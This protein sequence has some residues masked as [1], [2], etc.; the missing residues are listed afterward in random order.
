MGAGPKGW[1]AQQHKAAG[2]KRGKA[3]T[4]PTGNPVLDQIREATE[5][6]DRLSAQVRVA[7]AGYRTSVKY[8]NFPLGQ[9][10]RDIAAMLHFPG[11]AP[12]RVLSTTFGGF[13][14]HARQK[15]AHN[16]Q[17]ARLDQALAA[18]MKDLARTEIGQRAVVLVYSEFGRRV[19]ENG[20]QGTD[21][22]KGGPVFVLGHN[23]Q[24]GIFGQA[25]D[26]SDRDNGDVKVTTDFRSVYATLIEGLFDQDAAR[27]LGQTFPKVGFLA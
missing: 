12:P 17:M 6:A 16:R 3:K 21:H 10:L 27:L 14:T 24:G 18:L 15:G 11:G 19:N 9:N 4:E 22:G 8:P 7:T 25:P 5:N 23:I 20:S 1:A 2:K 13:D 26:L